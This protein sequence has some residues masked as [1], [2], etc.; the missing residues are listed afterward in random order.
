MI[1]VFSESF[2]HIARVSVAMRFCICAEQRNLTQSEEFF[3]LFVCVCVYD[4]VE[5][6][7][8]VLLRVLLSLSSVS[9][10]FRRV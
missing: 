4:V 3:G 1:I 9:T 2:I 8:F 6:D 10:G 7:A 5:S